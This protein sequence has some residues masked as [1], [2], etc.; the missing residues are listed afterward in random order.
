ML[1]LKH[2]VTGE[3]GAPK[4]H[5]IDQKSTSIAHCVLLYRS[6]WAG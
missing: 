1:L 3:G 6:N 4:V 5:P 2:M